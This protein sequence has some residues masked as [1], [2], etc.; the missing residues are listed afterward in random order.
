MASILP[1]SS[2]VAHLLDTLP[3]DEQAALIASLQPH[4]SSECGFLAPDEDLRTIVHNDA[5]FLASKNITFEQV[6]DRLDG[7]MTKAIALFNQKVSFSLSTDEVFFYIEKK[8]LVKIVSKYHGYQDC[9]FE[10]Y[11]KDKKCTLSGSDLN[12]AIVDIATERILHFAG[13]IR[14]LL[15]DHH[16]CEGPKAP[17]RFDIEKAVDIL[18]IEPGKVYTAPKKESVIWSHSSAYLLKKTTYECLLRAIPKLETPPLQSTD[19]QVVYIRIQ[20]R[21]TPRECVK[22]A[23]LLASFPEDSDIFVPSEGHYLY[24]LTTPSGINDIDPSLIGGSLS[25]AASL[26]Y[27]GSNVD[28]PTFTNIEIQEFVKTTKIEAVLDPEDR[29]I[30]VQR[31]LE[32]NR[33]IMET[34]PYEKMKR[35]SSCYH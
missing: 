13:L 26:S 12:F 33:I 16:F 32:L 24:V 18:N 28:D 22:D 35:T 10:K 20:A 8:F 34:A 15:K 1:T 17:L 31:Y 21:L 3:E 19:H 2:R 27:M 14:H 29:M 23:T 6:A 9:P 11:N 30:T 7:V 4:Q 25:R 5:L